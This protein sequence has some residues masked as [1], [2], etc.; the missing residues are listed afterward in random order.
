MKKTMWALYELRSN[1]IV[2]CA[3]CSKDLIL[4]YYYHYLDKHPD[5]F[6]II[7]F[8]IDEQK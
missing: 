2:G 6:R 7:S 8:E 3:W 5:Q 1:T 4:E